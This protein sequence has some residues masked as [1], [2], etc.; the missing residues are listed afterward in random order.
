MFCS[1]C[2]TQ[3][4]ENARFCPKCGKAVGDEG[5][6]RGAPATVAQATVA[7]ATGGTASVP[8]RKMALWK[9]IAIGLVLLI[10]LAVGLSIMATAPLVKPIEAHLALLKAGDI[11]GAY[12][13]TS[14]VFKQ[15]TSREAF[16][17]FIAARPVLKEI[18]SHTF[19]SRTRENG[20]GTV[21]GTLTA[22]DGTVIPV[23]YRLVQENG[24]WRILSITF[25]PSENAN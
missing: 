20:I 10:V 3:I 4:P 12:A 7:P 8:K 19:N 6:D 13:Q 23:M 24:E 21:S 16:V 15:E 2:G 9:K 14:G 25:N 18:T 22:Q 11:E 5:A 17:R 1:N